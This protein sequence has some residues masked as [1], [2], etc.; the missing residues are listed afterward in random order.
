VEPGPLR[1]RN[2]TIP[3]E[4]VDGQSILFLV[5]RVGER[6]IVEYDLAV[7]QPASQPREMSIVAEFSRQFG[8][9]PYKASGSKENTITAEA[10]LQA[11]I[12][13]SG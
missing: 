3:V 9:R 8:W 5:L 11:M 6:C 2:I 1:L 13:L 4:T 7:E 12:A 10:L